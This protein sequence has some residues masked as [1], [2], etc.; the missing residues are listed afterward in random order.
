MIIAVESHISP[1]DV[2]EP[3]SGDKRREGAGA[4]EMA[5]FAKK[6][7]GRVKAAKRNW[8]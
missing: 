2:S 5:G 4:F 3:L 6:P 7:I 8:C 1:D